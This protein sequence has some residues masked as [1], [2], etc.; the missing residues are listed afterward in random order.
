MSKRV[1]AK[2][3]ANFTANGHNLAINV[4]TPV[5]PTYEVITPDKYIF[6]ITG[7]WVGTISF[8]GAFFDGTSTVWQGIPARSGSGAFV[9]S[10]TGNGQFEVEGYYPGVR[11]IFTAFTS[12]TAVVKVTE[13]W[14][15]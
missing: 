3:P 10:T 7:T 4:P 8:E 13:V 12:G 14:D 5:A 9:V 1:S 15:V 2:L 6:N 11:A